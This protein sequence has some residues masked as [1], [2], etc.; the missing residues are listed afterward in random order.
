MVQVTNCVL[1]LLPLLPSLAALLRVSDE[2][3]L[4][5]LT[6]SL[7]IALVG[8]VVTNGLIPTVASYT[9]RAGL[10]GKDLGKKGTPAED[11]KV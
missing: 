2:S 7:V 11:K 8:F 3:A 1:A 10:F 4:R 9:E 5:M 6:E